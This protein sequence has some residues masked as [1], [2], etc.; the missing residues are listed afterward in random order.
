[1]DEMVY[2]DNLQVSN[3]HARIIEENHYYAYGLKIAAISSKKMPDAAEG[4]IDN[5]DLYNDKELIDDADLNWYDYGFRS[6]DP[7]IGRFPQLDPLTD[8][9]PE[10]TP[11]QY[12]GCEPIANVDLDGL[13]PAPVLTIPGRV[14]MRIVTS[15]AVETTLKV[16]GKTAKVVVMQAAKNP[17][18]WTKI[19]GFGLAIGSKVLGVV[20]A[21]LDPLPAGPAGNWEN[22]F[23]R[24]PEQLRPDYN[25]LPSITPSPKPNITKPPQKKKRTYIQYVLVADQDD[26]F[27]PDVEFDIM[28]RG[29]KEPQ[30]KMK[31]KRDDVWKYGTTVN[32]EKR[33]T[34]K[35]LK[36]KRL[37]MVRQTSGTKDEVLRR[38]KKKIQAYIK[39][40]G[41]RPP[42]NKQLN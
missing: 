13:E 37:R 24:H 23:V 38:E 7:Q 26:E 15:Q 36:E 27:E 14:T 16:V 42:G 33:Y 12:A 30:G 3:N 9:Y 10:L 29:F 28:E 39:K 6:Y 19:L 35:W 41:V 31:L 25:P 1:S 34:Q 22:Q 2:F 32:P 11:Y 18:T 4:H 21:V 20:G 5:K 40:Y 17:S 8:E